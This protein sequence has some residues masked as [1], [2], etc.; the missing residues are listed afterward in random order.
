MKKVLIILATALVVFACNGQTPKNKHTDTTTTPKT[1]TEK[2]AIEA[3]KKQ[4]HRFEIKGY[5]I[6]YNDQLMKLDSVTHFIKRIG[7]PSFNKRGQIVWGTIPIWG[8]RYSTMERFFIYFRPFFE[9]NRYFTEDSHDPTAK[10]LKQMPVIDGYMLVEGHPIH[11]DTTPKELSEILAPI[12]R[13]NFTNLMGTP[14][15]V[16]ELKEDQIK[17]IIP[18]WGADKAYDNIFIGFEFIRDPKTKEVK[19]LKSVEYSNFMM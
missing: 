12:Y 13:D 18:H 2:E 11:K 16:F 8:F 3:F 4:K 1:I 14:T 5:K 10:P 9:G 17:E 15:I 6:Y 7:E 19:G